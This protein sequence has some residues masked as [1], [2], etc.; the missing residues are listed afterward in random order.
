[1]SKITITEGSLYFL[2][3]KENS[4]LKVGLTKEDKETQDTKSLSLSS[5]SV[6]YYVKS[7]MPVSL[8]VAA[9]IYIYDRIIKNEI[10][11]VK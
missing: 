3:E 9:G 4:Y 6:G 5:E 7:M 11:C 10:T 1:M 2:T 8:G